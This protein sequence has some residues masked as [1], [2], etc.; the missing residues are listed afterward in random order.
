MKETAFCQ[1]SN[2]GPRVGDK[3]HLR[4]RSREMVKTAKQCEPQQRTWG[5]RRGDV[6]WSLLPEILRVTVPRKAHAE[7]F[8]R[9]LPHAAVSSTHRQCCS[10]KGRLAHTGTRTKIGPSAVMS[11]TR[12]A[13]TRGAIQELPRLARMNI[14]LMPASPHEAAQ[15][16]TAS[17][18]RDVQQQLWRPWTSSSRHRSIWTYSKREA[19]GLGTLQQLL[20]LPP[21]VKSEWDEV[22]RRE[23]DAE[24]ALWCSQVRRPPHSLFPRICRWLRDFVVEFRRENGQT[25][26]LGARDARTERLHRTQRQ[27][28]NYAIH[29]KSST[30]QS[31]DNAAKMREIELRQIKSKIPK[32]GSTVMSS[33][34]AKDEESNTQGSPNRSAMSPS[35][36]DTFVEC[37]TPCHVACVSRT[38]F[39]GLALEVCELTSACDRWL[40]VDSVQSTQRRLLALESR[41]DCLECCLSHRCDGSQVFG[42]FRAELEELPSIF[43]GLS[44]SFIF[45]SLNWLFAGCTHLPKRWS[46]IC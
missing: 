29:R 32:L 45:L 16:A 28:C 12:A 1:E 44:G 46:A 9:A 35:S 2:V 4:R 5:I 33:T 24:F 40:L 43:G 3:L 27:L 26:C 22:E 6:V 30:G 36:S 13:P 19:I 17:L 15:V 7:G 34:A 21:V 42:A 10:P 14:Q 8:S 18:F 39:V 41:A 11:A 31:D 38:G 37:F 23:A 25:C 20:Y